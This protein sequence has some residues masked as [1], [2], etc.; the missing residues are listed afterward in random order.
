MEIIRGKIS[1]Q[2]HLTLDSGI[3]SFGVFAFSIKVIQDLLP[4]Q[5]CSFQHLIIWNG[6]YGAVVRNANFHEQ[7]HGKRSA[8]RTTFGHAIVNL[9]ELCRC[10][11]QSV[12]GGWGLFKGVATFSHVGGS[13]ILFTATTNNVSINPSFQIWGYVLHVGHTSCIITNC[14][15]Y[16]RTIPSF[17]S[18][19]L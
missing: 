15:Q 16:Q 19:A 9:W 7:L 14:G 5:T 1:A 13:F 17:F 18:I 10:H 6:I 8:T 12:G 4:T 3:I 11:K 2:A